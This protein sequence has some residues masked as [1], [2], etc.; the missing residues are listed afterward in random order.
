MLKIIIA[1]KMIAYILASFQQVIGLIQ[2]NEIE[3]TKIRRSHN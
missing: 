2:Y 1:R 3:I